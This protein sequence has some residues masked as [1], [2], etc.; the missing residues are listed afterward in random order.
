ML[1]AVAASVGWG[2]ADFLGGAS[3]RDTP[4]LVI[5]AISETVGLLVLTPVLVGHDRSLPGD[6][7]LLL[8]GLAGLGVTVELGLI[9]AALSRGEAFVTAAVGALGAAAA[10]AFGLA[11]GDPLTLAI[12]AG[13]ICALAGGAI[14][15]WT[16]GGAGRGHALRSAGLCAGAAAGVA[17]MLTSFH[18]AGRVDPYWATTVEHASTAVLAGAVVPRASGVAPAPRARPATGHRAAGAGRCRG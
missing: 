9:Y 15:A 8:A 14:T 1:L 10:V 12:I 7:R 11:G 2:A 17:T 4:A 18:A 5:V 13:L 3:R 6:P 16:S